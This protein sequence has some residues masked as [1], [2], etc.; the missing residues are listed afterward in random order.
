MTSGWVRATAPSG[1]ADFVGEV[2]WS[3]DLAYGT[4]AAEDPAP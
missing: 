2:G 1:D 4:R 3:G